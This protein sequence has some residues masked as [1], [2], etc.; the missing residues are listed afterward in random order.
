MTLRKDAT[1]TD[2]VTFRLSGEVLAVPA[3]LLREVLEPVDIARVPG[4]PE[5]VSSL[6]NVRGTV[7]P[8]ADLRVPLRMPRDEIGAGARIMVLD[9]P[10]EGQD[11]VVGIY[12]DS[13]HEVTRLDAATMEAI[14]TVGSRWPPR[15]VAYVGRWSG[16][17][18]TIP[19]LPTIFADY[20]ASQQSRP[21][22]GASGA[23][24]QS[25]AEPV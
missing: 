12:A 19:D 5:F 4:A 2:V 23:I 20:L 21:S 6:I 10:L 16:A 17:F 7:V 3:S 15:F 14:P 22:S 1:T 13:V 8:L 11:A 9:L 24:T 25:E 18:V